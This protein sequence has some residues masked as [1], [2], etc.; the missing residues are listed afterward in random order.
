MRGRQEDRQRKGSVKD[1]VGKAR[2]K[3][4][5]P[6]EGALGEGYCKSGDVGEQRQKEEDEGMQMQYSL[7]IPQF[8]IC[9]FAAPWVPTPQIGP[10][11][12]PSNMTRAM[13]QI[14]I[15][16]GS[17]RL[18]AE[19]AHV[20]LQSRLVSERQFRPPKAT[21]GFWQM[22]PPWIKRPYCT[23]NQGFL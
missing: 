17:G 13:R 5:D 19:A 20:Y 18:S 14:W 8:G 15:Q 4:K 1:Q 7:I 16:I 22:E 23:E 9:G 21:S 2:Q 12:H 6:W 11:H 10:H 3:Q